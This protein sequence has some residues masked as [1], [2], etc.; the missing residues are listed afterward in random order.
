MKYKVGD[1]T[2]ANNLL[3]A[4]KSIHD[5]IIEIDIKHNVYRFK[6]KDMHN[7]IGAVDINNY[8]LNTDLDEK[9]MLKKQFEEE[10]NEIINS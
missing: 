9:Y 2:K 1:H 5:E 8:D 6:Q 3:W 7:E 10:M 4:N